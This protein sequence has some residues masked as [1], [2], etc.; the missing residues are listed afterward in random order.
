[1]YRQPTLL[2]HLQLVLVGLAAS[3]LIASPLSGEPSKENK[4]KAAY[5]LNFTR[6]IT[7]P[8]ET[9]EQDDYALHICLQDNTPFQAFFNELVLGRGVSGN[10]RHIVVQ[11]LSEAS[12]CDL[13]YLY[14]TQYQAAAAADYGLTVLDSARVSEINGAIVFYIS[15]RKLRFEIDLERAESTGVTISSELLKL[16]R[17]R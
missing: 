4:L 7:W 10:R 14:Q 1:M 16:A 13:T 8:E 12:H 2:R 11:P 9:A 17:I 5:L 3:L 6:F 15:D